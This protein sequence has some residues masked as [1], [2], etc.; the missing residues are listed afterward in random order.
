MPLPR[1]CATRAPAAQRLCQH[2]D[3]LAAA[4]TA[5]RTPGPEPPSVVAPST[6]R[7]HP[8]RRRVVGTRD[9]G[10]DGGRGGGR[11]AVAC[12]G[13]G[14]A[15]AAAGGG[16]CDADMGV[17]GH[18]PV[19]RHVTSQES[20]QNYILGPVYT[21]FI[22]PLSKCLPTATPHATPSPSSTSSSAPRARPTPPSAAV[23]ARTSTA[24]LPT[25]YPTTAAS[26]A[27]LRR[28]SR[29]W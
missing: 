27:R 19:L 29:Q 18:G 12:A 11:A 26:A 24:L 9:E 23:S 10:G 28:C 5:A 15:V 25:Q 16:W 2:N 13:V 3:A 21:P 4:Q 6:Q 22:P 14:V 8:R 17:G 7:G 20:T 1:L